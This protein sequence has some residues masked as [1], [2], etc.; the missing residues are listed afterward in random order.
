MTSNVGFTSIEVAV[1]ETQRPKVGFVGAE[2]LIQPSP[3]VNVGFAAVQVITKLN[4]DTNRRLT[5]ESAE[6]IIKAAR[7]PARVT[8]EVAEAVIGAPTPVAYV[9]N[10]NVDVMLTGNPTANMSWM[11]TE[12]LMSVA[13]A[14]QSNF[15]WMGLE[16]LVPAA[17]KISSNW[18]GLEMLVDVNLLDDLPNYLDYGDVYAIPGFDL[19]SYPLT[20][21]GLSNGTTITL[22]SY[23]DLKFSLD[24]TNFSST[25]AVQN[26]SQVY[27]TK[28]PANIFSDT[29]LIYTD[30][31]FSGET[32][33]GIWKL[34]GPSQAIMYD[35]NYASNTT[36]TKNWDEYKQVNFEQTAIDA[37]FSPIQNEASVTIS[38]K[39]DQFTSLNGLAPTSEF[40]DQSSEIKFADAPASEFDDQTSEIKFADAPTSEFDDQSSEIKFTDAPSSLFVSGSSYYDLVESISSQFFNNIHNRIIAANSAQQKIEAYNLK[41]LA[42]HDIDRYNHSYVTTQPIDAIEG[43]IALPLNWR[44][45]AM[46]MALNHL[47]EEKLA[48]VI[49]ELNHLEE[50]K[51]V[52]ELPIYWVSWEN[53]QVMS[54][55]FFEN[56]NLKIY[57]GTEWANLTN[58]NS[59]EVTP[60]WIYEYLNHYDL[61]VLHSEYVPWIQTN[62]LTVSLNSELLNLARTITYDI[63]GKIDQVAKSYF[64][65]PLY[66][67]EYAID[68]LKTINL[69]AVYDNE[70]IYNSDNYVRQGGYL[71]PELAADAASSYPSDITIVYQ[72]PEGTFSY[73]VLYT[74]SVWCGDVPVQP[75]LKAIAWYLG[76]G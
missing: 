52:S 67:Y 8:G 26:N 29:Y 75:V 11:G 46:Q 16:F 51:L 43:K 57:I 35:Y 22:Y 23:D 49:F 3:G 44:V 25:V 63:N 28:H 39:L 19:Y 27:L 47:E 10:Q 58:K 37:E 33:V 31:S 71:T 45:V 59:Y 24:G 18:I 74:N 32:E 73:N 30:S 6:V 56:Y 68:S 21:G 36:E 12:L 53:R 5:A 40:D 9:S 72:Q 17:P 61:F 55:W 20:I 2:V 69:N 62:Y 15:S 70:K 60:Q 38:N 4:P 7:A 50:E 41:I 76:G 64:V 65:N 42:G 48:N 34:V 13:P 1:T 14:V 66:S 54:Q